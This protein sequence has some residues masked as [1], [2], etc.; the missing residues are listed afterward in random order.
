MKHQFHNSI[1]RE[2]DIRGIVGST[3]RIKDAYFIGKKFAVDIKKK[4]MWI[5]T[6]RILYRHRHPK[7]L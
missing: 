3:L 2:Y 7:R 4:Y 5:Y 6:Q 1:L